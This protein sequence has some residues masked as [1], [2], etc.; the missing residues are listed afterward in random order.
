[1]REI[2][3]YKFLKILKTFL[4]LNDFILFDLRLF[5]DHILK[6]IYIQYL[7]EILSAFVIFHAFFNFVFIIF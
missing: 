2:V 3:S 7:N 4:F 1:M 6:Q 5:Q